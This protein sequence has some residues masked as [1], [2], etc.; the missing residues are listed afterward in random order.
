MSG[1]I[2]VSG[3]GI[4]GCC[5][6]WWLRRYGYA[7]TIVEQAAEPR[8]GG[9]VIDFWGLGYRVAEK[10]G[11]VDELRR[12][13]LVIEEFRVVDRNGRK[14][15]GI[16][17]RALQDIA[18]GRIMSLQRSA[19]AS[20]LYHAL[21]DDVSVRFGDSVATLT[22]HPDGVEVTFR[23][24]AHEGYD[25]VVGADGLHSAVRHLAFGEQAEYERFL[26][27]YVAA[28]SAH[29]YPHRDPHVYVTYGEPGKQ[30]WRVTMDDETTVFL[31]VFADASPQGIP[32]HDPAQQK[33]ILARRYARSG[34]ETPDMLRALAAT[35]DLYFDRVSQIVMPRWTKGRVALI[36]DACACPSLLAGEGSA[37]AMA[38]AYT[39]AGELHAASG[40]HAAAFA[41]YEQLLR[42]YVERKQKAARG[43]AAS[44]VPQSALALWLRNT[45]INV[46]NTLGLTRLLFG[47]QIND[48]QALG[49]YR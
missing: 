14:I 49:D 4:A 8:A 18:G 29:D 41:A 27:Y 12:S 30:I 25:L 32:M 47:A 40:D 22:E 36:G 33:E 16:D 46:A 35:T 20:A 31:L 1:K 23:S 10:M 45:S 6:A 19:V 38:E 17:Q 48:R 42:P 24:G 26:G 43:F 9:Y 11:L 28:F 13:D 37:M 3:G 15:S 21:D 44:F 7:V 5:L 2:L 39:L 34:W